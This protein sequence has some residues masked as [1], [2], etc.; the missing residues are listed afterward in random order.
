LSQNAEA[1]E[2]KH[3]GVFKK[4]FGLFRKDGGLSEKDGYVYK[5]SVA[6]EQGWL[7]D[8]CHPPFAPATDEL[9][10]EDDTSC[11]GKMYRLVATRPYVFHRKF[12]RRD[13][14]QKYAAA[15]YLYAAAK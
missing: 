1:F 11:R 5:N 3:F 4:H 8:S 7:Q 15:E 9:S 10:P 14:S 6:G 12:V 13:S 2:V